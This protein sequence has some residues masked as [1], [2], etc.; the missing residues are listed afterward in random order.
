MRGHLGYSAD[1]ASRCAG[2]TP[3]AREERTSSVKNRTKPMPR[4]K[5]SRSQ[6]PDL[7]IAPSLGGSVL[8]SPRCQFCPPPN[9]T[10]VR[11]YQR[12][13]IDLHARFLLIRAMS[14]EGHV[15]NVT[16]M[17]ARAPPPVAGLLADCQE[18]IGGALSSPSSATAEAA[19]QVP[20]ANVAGDPSGPLTDSKPRPA[21]SS[22]AIWAPTSQA[23]SALEFT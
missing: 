13:A 4:R 11:P 1:N 9:M 18:I 6:A 12:V 23:P 5:L 14:C 8:V 2:S 3:S 19:S 17:R 16:A 22:L 20:A 7:T 10:V 15:E 21:M